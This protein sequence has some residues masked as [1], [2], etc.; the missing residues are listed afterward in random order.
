[1]ANLAWG[2]LQKSQPPADEVPTAPANQFLKVLQRVS[3]MAFPEAISENNEN[4][5][6]NGAV[7]SIEQE[8]TSASFLRRP[9]STFLAAAAQLSAAAEKRKAMMQNPETQAP[10]SPKSAQAS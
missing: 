7:N 1:M 10:K 3:N 5:E 4:N 6:N 2:M 8:N 9:A